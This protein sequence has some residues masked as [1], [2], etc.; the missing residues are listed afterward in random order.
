[1]SRTHKLPHQ[2]HR[3]APAKSRA[4]ANWTI[5]VDT[6]TLKQLLEAAKADVV[7]Y[8]N[9]LYN[10]QN[11]ARLEAL[12]TIHNIQQIWEMLG[13][14]IKISEICNASGKPKQFRKRRSKK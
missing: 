6:Q 4:D 7:V 12:A 10:R 13:Q 5:P 1:M 14:P 8:E 9:E 2:T 3:P 11:G